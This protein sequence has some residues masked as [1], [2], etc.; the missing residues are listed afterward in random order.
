MNSLKNKRVI[1]ITA[2]IAL[3]SI[4]TIGYASLS[5][6][7]NINGNTS[8][9]S[10]SWIIYFDNVNEITKNA[11]ITSSATIIHDEKDEID[12]KINFENP[13]ESYEFTADIVNDGTIDAMID[14]IQMTGIDDDIKN[15]IEW[16]ITYLDNTELQKCDELL[17]E[18]RRKIRVIVNYKKDITK[19]DLPTSTTEKTFKLK[20]NYVQLDDKECT[21]KHESNKTHYLTIDPNGA[22]YDHSTEKRRIEINEGETYTLLNI[23]NPGYELTSWESNPENSLNEE[24]NVVTMGKK[25]IS[26][27]ANWTWKEGYCFGVN[28]E[29][30]QTIDEA[31]NSIEEKGTIK[32]LHETCEINTE[33]SNITIPSNKDITIDLN[34]YDITSLTNI[35][36]TGKLE[37]TNSKTNTPTYTIN[38]NDSLNTAFSNNNLIKLSNININGQIEKIIDSTGESEKTTLNNITIDNKNKDNIIAI[39]SENDITADNTIINIDNSSGTVKGIYSKNNFAF[40]NITINMKNTNGDIIKGIETSKTIDDSLNN[41]NVDI[42][43]NNATTLYGVQT[44]STGINGGSIKI[45]QE[46]DETPTYDNGTLISALYTQDPNHVIKRINM[47]DV[48]IDVTTVTN[49][50]IPVYTY[51]SGDFNNI[52]IK[53]DTTTQATGVIGLRGSGEINLIDSSI[54]VKAPNSSVVEGI[55]IYRWDQNSYLKNTSIKVKGAQMTYG[56]NIN[57]PAYVEN[58]YIESDGGVYPNGIY[59][60]RIANIKDSEIVVKSIYGGYGIQATHATEVINTKITAT[61]DRT[62]PGANLNTFLYGISGNDLTIT[63]SEITVNGNYKNEDGEELEEVNRSVNAVFTGKATIKNSKLNSSS[64]AINIDRAGDTATIDELTTLTYKFG[65]KTGDGTLI[66]E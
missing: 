36:N 48:D 25:D 53:V 59:A 47:K 18:S 57:S 37:I 21:I 9:A 33:N 60:Q 62:R 34:G 39:T 40:D 5:R 10:N 56:V 58:C 30:Y 19:A 66:R 22:Y 6:R 26:L 24:T 23:V 12:F 14:D 1:Y 4:I 17:K 13:G 49:M 51:W 61:S 8:I 52:N 15:I 43:Y 16:K 54:E 41:I 31:I 38:G 42:K 44:I 27:K 32:V 11:D 64:Y 7:L 65:E 3:I 63:D 2:A 50:P 35:N 45:T 29:A 28:E 46:S 20:I 55:D